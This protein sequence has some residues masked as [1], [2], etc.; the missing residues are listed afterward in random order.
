MSGSTFQAKHARVHPLGNFDARHSGD[1]HRAI[2]AVGNTIR[3]QATIMVYSDAF[4]L[5]GLVLLGVA[6]MGKGA[7][8]GEAAHQ[9]KS[10]QP[11]VRICDCLGR[12]LRRR[13][14]G[15]RFHCD[16]DRNVIELCGRDQGSIE[17][18]T[19]YVP[20]PSADRERGNLRA[21][22]KVGSG[23]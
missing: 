17:G 4:A 21:K 10:E 14:T 6:I 18:I 12:S 7:A 11:F 3:A 13:R 9:I 16:P 22:P 1:C 5:I 19:R 15:L 20:S 2:I 23:A 8:A